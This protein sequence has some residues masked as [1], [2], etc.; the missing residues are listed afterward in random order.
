MSKYLRCRLI[1]NTM[2]SMTAILRARGDGESDRY[3]SKPEVTAMAKR[4][5]QYY[6]MLQDKGSKKTSWV[7]VYAQ[8]Y[9]RLQ[10]VRSPQKTS[11]DGAHTKK[12]RVRRD[13]DDSSDSTVILDCSSDGYSSSISGS[14]EREI[15]SPDTENRAAMATW[16]SPQAFSNKPSDVSSPYSDSLAGTAG[17]TRGA[18]CPQLRHCPPS[19]PDPAGVWRPGWA[20]NSWQ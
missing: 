6:P 7:T 19:P 13:T 17:D 20:S 14:K 12:R 18:S 11:P 10:N 3:P 4:I 1:W 2:T 9:K 15:D 5:V 8:P 16:S